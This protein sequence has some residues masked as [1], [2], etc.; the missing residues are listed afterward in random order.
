MGSRKSRLKRNC[1]SDQ[2]ANVAR[3]AD[4]KINRSVFICMQMKGGRFKNGLFWGIWLER[5]LRQTDGAMW[6]SRI[7]Q[8][9]KKRGMTPRLGR[10]RRLR[11]PSGKSQVN[12]EH[13]LAGSMCPICTLMK[14]MVVWLSTGNYSAGSLA[15][16]GSRSLRKLH[17][18]KAWCS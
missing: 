5:R 1:Q 9:G 10:G 6:E 4:F 15:T 7:G 2:S 8:G 14:K 13:N 11:T 17:D 12:Y 3:S 16:L 18:T